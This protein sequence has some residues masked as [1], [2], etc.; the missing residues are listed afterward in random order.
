MIF[1]NSATRRIA[2]KGVMAN[3]RIIIILTVCFFSLWYNCSI[4]QILKYYLPFCR[5]ILFLLF[6]SVLSQI[7]GLDSKSSINVT[8]LYLKTAIFIRFNQSIPT[9]FYTNYT[10]KSQFI[11]ILWIS[12][13]GMFLRMNIMIK[14]EVNIKLIDI[15]LV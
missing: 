11:L 14:I 2:V 9:K 13:L 6:S 7:Q 5:S 15:N 12:F 4:C 10:H 3:K 1:A 8:V